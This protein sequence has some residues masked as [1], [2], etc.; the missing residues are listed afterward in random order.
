MA[1]T[2]HQTPED[3]TPGYSPQIFT[4]SSTQIAQPNFNYTVV[5]TDLISSETQ[6]YQIP[7]RPDGKLV[8]N[9]KNFSEIYLTHDLPINTYGFQTVDGIRKIRVNIG[10]TYGTNPAYAS[11]ANNDFIVW[12]GIL[13][14]KEYPIYN[15]ANYVYDNETENIKYLNDIEVEDTFEDRS[16]YLYTLGSK[17][18]DTEQIV[19]TTYD[20]S[21]TELSSTT[22]PNPY[23]ASTTYTD[24]YLCI[25]VGHKGLTEMPSGLITGDYPI[26]PANC[27]YYTVEDVYDDGFDLILTL[28]KTIYIK[29]EPRYDVYTVHYLR[30]DGSFQT[31]NFQKLSKRIL[32]KQQTDYSKL[33]FTYEANVYSYNPSSRT[34][35][36]LSSERQE[37]LTL[38]TDWMTEEE[39]DYHQDLIDS[40][41][42]YLDFGSD[43]DYL[44]VMVVTNSYSI[45]KRYNERMYN[46]T[47]DFE[48]AHKN[49][50]QSG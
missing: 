31:L 44:Q 19:I 35:Y 13:D 17:A 14:Y 34:R 10:E 2:V 11:G 5:C 38:N 27:A 8:F 45:N 32:N 41:V 3:Y 30:K 29:C 6:T 37:V 9:A 23:E 22:I 26:L 12:N 18:G 43:E 46:L 48:Y 39:V 16:N 21:G 28:I 40:P 49:Q 1:V 50:R 47:I 33:P 7:Q 42:V 20:G 36:V 15:P 24:K 4:A 25:D